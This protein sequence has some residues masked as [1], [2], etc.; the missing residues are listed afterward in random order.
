VPTLRYTEYVEPP[1]P[2]TQTELCARWLLD[3]LAAAGAPAKPLDIVHAAAVEGFPRA[4]VYRARNTLADRV[5]ALGNSRY[6]PSRR[7]TL[8]PPEPASEDEPPDQDTAPGS[9]A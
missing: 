2:P 8:A 9:F 5:L 1:P 6:D 7:W 4:T 3:Y